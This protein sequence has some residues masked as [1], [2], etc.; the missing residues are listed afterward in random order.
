MPTTK[1]TK[2]KVI[3]PLPKAPPVVKPQTSETPTTKQAVVAPATG[4]LWGVTT[5]MTLN[6]DSLATTGGRAFGLRLFWGDA[7]ADRANLWGLAAGVETASLQSHLPELNGQKDSRISGSVFVDRWDI[8]REKKLGSEDPKPNW[9]SYS[10][11]LRGLG[12]S[13]FCPAVGN[14]CWA[15]LHVD[16]VTSIKGLRY[17]DMSGSKGFYAAFSA[18]VSTKTYLHWASDETLRNYSHPAREFGINFAV[19][20]GYGDPSIGEA[21]NETL[22]DTEKWHEIFK[23]ILEDISLF[24]SAKTAGDHQQKANDLLE[25]AG[26]SNTDNSTPPT[27]T[28]AT[29][30]VSTLLFLNAVSSGNEKSKRLKL[31]DKMSGESKEMF[32]WAN[33]GNTALLAGAALAKDSN[34]LLQGALSSLQHTANLIPAWQGATP[35]TTY[36]VRFAIPHLMALASMATTDP[37]KRQ[38]F[39]MSATEGMMTESDVPL[40]SQSYSYSFNHN[41]TQSFGSGQL[42]GPRSEAGVEKKLKSGFSTRTAIASPVIAFQNVPAIGENV[43]TNIGIVDGNGAA[44]SSPTLPTTAS[45]MVGWRGTVGNSVY[46]TA[47]V[48]GGLAVNLG[49][50]D[51]PQLG[52]TGRA[53]IGAGFGGFTILE[54][55]WYLGAEVFASGTKSSDSTL[56]DKGVAA[57]LTIR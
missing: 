30:E 53:S 4:T 19:D 55:K 22:N 48:F 56:L 49:P 2:S 28:T 47:S 38:S 34:T 40:E 32:F 10:K 35:E 17:K 24:F 54:K 52:V 6:Y 42:K 33:A 18:N 1:K 39:L 29:T 23:Y 15:A 44:V 26:L 20:F 51:T 5:Y 14:T 27:Q 9:N 8:S 46:G 31:F 36:W 43:A 11:D 50:Q 37:G 45:S 57:T 41:T 21:A 25:S 7:F 3:R 16:S 12:I 13:Q